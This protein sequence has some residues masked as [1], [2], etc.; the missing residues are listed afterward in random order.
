[1][2][3]I[4]EP[5]VIAPV[6]TKCVVLLVDDQTMIGEAL[7]RMLVSEADIE[8]H[9]CQAAEHALAMAVQLKPT[10]ILQDI[11]M[12]E[13]DGLSLLKEYRTAS[14]T[15]SVPVIMLSTRDDPR[16]KSQAFA[17]GASDYLV[18]IPDQIELI[19]RIR[20]HSRSYLA[21]LQR[22]EAFRQLHAV[23]RQL[24]ASNRELHRISC[25]DGLTGIYNRRHFD[26][27][28]DQEWSRALREGSNISLV[29]A[30]IDYFKTFNDHYGHLAGDECLQR[31]ARVFREVLQRPGDLAARYGGEEFVVV[32]PKT[33]LEGAAV[34]AESIRIRVERLSITHEFSKVEKWV[35][36]S[37][38]IAT[39][40]P[41]PRMRPPELVGLADKALYQAK[42]NGRNRC[43]QARSNLDELAMLHNRNTKTEGDN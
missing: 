39:V 7:R 21:Q 14:Q 4:I 37:V 17:A 24:E 25:Q 11:V 19:A 13:S 1:M 12:P 29:L 10:V 35:T 32:L 6:D 36:L 20:A 16:Y 31:V 26:T 3:E 22:D 5:L 38:G 9:Y 2:S 15:R 27:Y 18:K 23:Q 42:Q 8:Y 33:D 40:R 34:I 43:E 30:D 41:N 28:L